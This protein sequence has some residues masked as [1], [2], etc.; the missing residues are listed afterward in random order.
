MQRSFKDSNGHLPELNNSE[1]N[2]SLNPNSLEINDLSNLKKSDFKDSNYL[3]AGFESDD[4]F[5]K[6]NYLQSIH[7]YQVG[8]I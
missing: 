3:P 2:G 7:F 5:D 6:V 8:S 4:D 1:F